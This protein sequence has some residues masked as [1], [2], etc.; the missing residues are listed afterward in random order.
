MGKLLSLKNRHVP[1]NLF[2]GELNEIPLDAKIVVNTINQYS[3]C[4]AEKDLIFK[5]ALNH[6]DVLLP[7]GEGVVFA[8]RLLGGNKLK[9][10]SG[11][12]LHLHLLKSLNVTG[13]RIFYLGSSE[14]T[15]QKIKIK[16]Q[17]EYP[18]LE[19]AYYSPPFKESFSVTDNEE[20]IVAINHF[21]PDILFV[22]LTAPKQEK[23]SFQFKNR[24][25]AHL[26]CAIG[27]VF[28][29]YAETVKRPHKLFI[30]Y[31]LEWMG[32]LLSNPKRM[33]K[34]YLYYGPVYVFYILKLKFS[35]PTPDA[36]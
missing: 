31:R 16:L 7:D 2:S 19:M 18:N 22:G 32:R 23:W 13:G 15:L 8:E 10:I 34:R 14:N 29:F 36:I 17:R 27:A 1:Y 28:D 5:E 33:W 30:K 26:I 25:N 4:M 6:S 12:D 11:T 21:V 3:F 35:K 20:M 9:K 24:I